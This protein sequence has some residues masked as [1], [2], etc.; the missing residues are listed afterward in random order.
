VVGKAIDN[1]QVAK[2]V[3][4]VRTSIRE[5]ESIAVPLQASGMFPPMVIQMVKVGEETGALETMLNKVADFYDAEIDNTV[6]SLTSILEPIL[7]VGM[8]IVIGAMLISL[9]LPIFNLALS[10]KGGIASP[11]GPRPAGAARDVPG[12]LRT[13]SRGPTDRGLSRS[14]PSAWASTS[15]T[16]PPRG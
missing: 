2:A 10:V 15:R 14:V 3:E 9:Y 7:I 8:G 4:S 6:A 16:H 13:S 5:G 1:V 12:A 11:S